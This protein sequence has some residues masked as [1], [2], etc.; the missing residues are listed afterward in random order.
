MTEKTDLEKTN[1][2]LTD[3]LDTLKTAAANMALA[4]TQLYKAGNPTAYAQFKES[5]DKGLVELGLTL[6]ITPRPFVQVF[7]ALPGG[8]RHVFFSLPSVEVGGGPTIN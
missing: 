6:F 2:I 7:A 5:F 4:A 1:E 8:E 3:R